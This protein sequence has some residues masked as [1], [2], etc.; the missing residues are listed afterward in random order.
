MRK[1]KLSSVIVI[2]AFRKHLYINR[3]RIPAMT[4]TNDS[5]NKMRRKMMR[6]GIGKNKKCVFICHYTRLSIY[7]WGENTLH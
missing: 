7:L 6:L 4:V 3:M 1:N 2:D 5:Q